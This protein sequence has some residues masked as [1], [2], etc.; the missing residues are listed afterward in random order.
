MAEAVFKQFDLKMVVPGFDSE[1]TDLIIE[2]DH[3]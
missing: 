1:L 2:L 3:L